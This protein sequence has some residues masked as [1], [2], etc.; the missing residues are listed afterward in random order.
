[1]N[2]YALLGV[3]PLIVYIDLPSDRAGILPHHAPS[4]MVSNPRLSGTGSGKLPRI[5]PGRSVGAT[6]TSKKGVGRHPV[7][8]LTLAPTELCLPSPF[9][10]ARSNKEFLA[11][12]PP[13]F[14]PQFGSPKR[15]KP[16]PPPHLLAHKPGRIAGRQGARPQARGQRCSWR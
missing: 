5:L 10:R 7:L 11:T 2:S 16:K 3:F 12:Y 8:K 15:S 14:L 9:L 13:K 4:A 6:C 1:M